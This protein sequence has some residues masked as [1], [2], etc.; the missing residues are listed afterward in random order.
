M[1]KIRI[2]IIINQ[3]IFGFSI[4]SILCLGVPKAYSSRL[5][6]CRDLA[7]AKKGGGAPSYFLNPPPVLLPLPLFNVVPPSFLMLFFC[8]LF[9]QNWS[10]N[11]SELF[12][13]A[14]KSL[15]ILF[16]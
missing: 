14:W 8:C 13:K 7:K 4:S 10:L 15:L 9:G 1:Q 11:A 2:I 12:L 3:V 6:Y 5:G 16:I